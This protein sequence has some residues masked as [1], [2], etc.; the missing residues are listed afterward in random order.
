[1]GFA[2]GVEGCN[3]TDVLKEADDEMYKDK[4]ARKKKR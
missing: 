2:V 4:S 3:L 1:V